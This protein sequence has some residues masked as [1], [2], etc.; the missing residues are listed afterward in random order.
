MSVLLLNN[1]NDEYEENSENSMT[2]SMLER[3]L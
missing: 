1:D 2:S 3:G